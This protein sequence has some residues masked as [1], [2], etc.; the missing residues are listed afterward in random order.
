MYKIRIL[1]QKNTNVFTGQDFTRVSIKTGQINGTFEH[2]LTL[3]TQI[4]IISIQLKWKWPGSSIDEYKERPQVY[5][6]ANPVFN[7]LIILAIVR[8]MNI[9]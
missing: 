4:R 9:L 2:N 6:C 8:R 3:T 7:Y 5:K 1:L